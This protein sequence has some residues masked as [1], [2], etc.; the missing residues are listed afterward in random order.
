[1]T[2]YTIVSSL[3]GGG[4]SSWTDAVPTFSALQPGT[5]I[6]QIVFVIDT[7]SLYEWNG[8]NWVILLSSSSTITGPG[9][10]VTGDIVTFADTSGKVLADSGKSVTIDGTLSAN[11]DSLLPT[12]KAVK[13]YVD[14]G[15]GTKQNTLG[16]IAENVANKG[17]ANGYV[18]LD[19]GTKIPISYLP[20]STMIY[21]GNWDASSNTPNLADGTGVNGDMYR[22]SVAGTQTFNS[23]SINFLV[24]EFVIYNGTVWQQAPASDGVISINGHQGVVSVTTTD[25]PEGTNEYF[26]VARAQAAIS[27]TAPIVDTAGVISIP[28]ATTA[29]DGYLSHSDWNTFNSKQ[30]ALGFTPE[31]VANKTTDGTLSANS[32]T[33]YPSEKAVKT[34]ADTKAT[35]IIPTTS[36]RVY[37]NY[38]VGNDGTGD[39]SSDSPFKTV[40]H[41]L[42]T[43]TDANQNKPYSIVLGAD[44]QIETGDVFLK[45]YTFIIGDVQRATYFRVNGGALKP[46]ASWGSANGWTGM[47]NLY[48]G[49]A[50]YLNFDMTVPGGVGGI[51]LIVQNCTLSGNVNFKGRTSGGGDF[52]EMYVGLVLGTMTLDS[53]YYQIQSIAIGGNVSILN[54]QALG[55]LSGTFF[56]TSFESNVT[57]DATGGALT[58]FCE[59]ALFATTT[60]TLTTV[61]SVTWQGDASSFPPKSRQALSGTT[62]VAHIDDCTVNYYNPTTPSNWASVPSDVKA[63]L[64]DVAL[65]SNTAS[66][67]KTGVLSSS[68]WSTFN[69]KQ[70]AGNY[71]TN[72]TGDVVANGPGSVSATI[73]TNAVTNSKLAQAPATTLKGNNTG[74]T[75]NVTDLTPA[76]VTAILPTFV[77][78]TGTGGTQ[79]LVPAPT[80]G[81]GVGEYFL[82][83]SGSFSF[84]DQSKPFNNPFSLINMTSQP[85]A[86][87]KLNGV[88]IMGN[89]A[90]VVGAVSA[91]LSIYDISNQTKPVLKSYMTTLAG[92][93]NCYPF[94]QSSVSYV[95]VPSSGGSTLYIIDVTNPS[96]PVQAGHL[97]ISGTP[98]SLYSCVVA[99]GF[100]YIATQNKGLT[101]VDIGGGTGSIASPIQVY[102]EGGT[103]NRSFGVAFYNATTLFTTNYQTTNPWTVRYLKTWN[104]ST[105]TA[106]SLTNTYTLPAGTKPLGVTVFGNTAFV[107]DANTNTAQVIDV[108][109]PA[110]PVYKS[111]LAASG[112]FNSGVLTE[113]ATNV[114]GTSGIYA[115]LPSGSSAI[116][117]GFIDMFDVSN[118]SSPLKIATVTTG[119]ANSVFGAIAISGGYIYGADYGVAPGSSGSLDVFTMPFQSLVFGSGVGDTLTIKGSISSGG[120][121]V[122]RIEAPFTLS[123]TDITNKYITLSAT[124]AT[125]GNTQLNIVSGTDQAYTTDFIVTGNQLSWS[126]LGL[127][128]V[129]SVGDILTVLHD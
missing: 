103:L 1:M 91:T 59:N 81:Q 18:P 54:S 35:H 94:V 27:A 75:A 25:I 106:P 68:D 108:T 46:D 63:A 57:A 29:V 67:T 52:L 128:G 92:A 129:L 26:T 95:A 9:S 50:S 105:P 84:V 6:G 65:A 87:S 120:L 64:D 47:S 74:I 69:A 55:G 90:Y 37:V 38:L 85:A 62:T 44:R 110:A 60:N 15:L 73:Q 30:P 126:G 86:L 82:N 49:G 101:V 39:G 109:T 51:V 3:G 121:N 41:A 16:Y 14:T 22:V 33:L 12:E 89:Y 97:A 123:S 4:S 21:L 42:T 70:P 107:S 36:Q 17:A 111:S 98:G 72:L 5:S 76:Q 80:A 56:R 118:T 83:A 40:Q 58:V 113:V 78:D 2:T 114:V 34:Y 20:A 61:G 93:Y 88:S 45:P 122:A 102:Q 7:S 23:L 117:G 31:N 127:D 96:A 112:L 116:S 11:S 104:I 28:A 19:A 66:A 24:G 8:T 99:N 53:V 100:V 77:G 124:P 32:D 125:P 13:T 71:I 119:V 79:G 43:I 115:F 10:S 48:F